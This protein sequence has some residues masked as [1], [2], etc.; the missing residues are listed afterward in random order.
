MTHAS[1]APRT[2]RATTRLAAEGIS[3]RRG[4]V[5]ANLHKSEDGRRVGNY[6]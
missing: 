3:Q 4:F 6:A 1:A 5:S 2:R